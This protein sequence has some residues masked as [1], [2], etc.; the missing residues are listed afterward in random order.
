[1]ITAAIINDELFARKQRLVDRIMKK[2]PVE[3]SIEGVPLMTIEKDG[4]QFDS[5]S[6]EYEHEHECP[7]LIPSCRGENH[8]NFYRRPLISLYADVAGVDNPQ[9]LLYDGDG[10]G[11]G[12]DFGE[13]TEEDIAVVAAG[14]MYLGFDEGEDDDDDEKD[15]EEVVRERAAMHR[16]VAF[17]DGMSEAVDAYVSEVV[18]AG[19]VANRTPS[20]DT[21]VEEAKAEHSKFMA[22]VLKSTLL[23]CPYPV[24][25]FIAFLARSDTRVNPLAQPTP[26]PEAVLSSSPELAAE[27]LKTSSMLNVPV[28]GD[29]ELFGAMV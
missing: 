23:D 18:D 14:N 24:T 25:D 10:D 20:K 4:P 17:V 27:P 6:D 15:S 9:A 11:N 12:D 13:S 3:V 1:M 7:C 22:E 29:A 21:T 2:A 28:A 19:I 16:V 5:E 8:V 26:E